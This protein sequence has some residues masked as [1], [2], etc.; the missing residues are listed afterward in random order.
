MNNFIATLQR[1]PKLRRLAF[2]LRELWLVPEVL[3]FRSQSKGNVSFDRSDNDAW[4]SLYDEL[5][6]HFGDAL[7]QIHHIYIVRDSPKMTKGF[8]DAGTGTM[9]T[10]V[11]ELLEGELSS[12]FP[13]G[14]IGWFYEREQ[15]GLY[16]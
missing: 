11:L 8:R 6:R 16:L 2:S 13:H 4:N 5:V 10:E 12:R 9:K 3:S 7:P 1:P 15:R 14:I